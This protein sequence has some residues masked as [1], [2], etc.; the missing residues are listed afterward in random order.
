MKLFRALRNIFSPSARAARRA[1]REEREEASEEA[2]KYWQEKLAPEEDRPD[3]A[4][5]GYTTG[6]S[7]RELLRK[8]ALM[9]VLKDPYRLEGGYFFKPGNQFD[10]LPGELRNKIWNMVLPPGRTII[11]E[12]YEPIRHNLR[13]NRIT[14]RLGVFAYPEDRKQHAVVQVSRE[15]RDIY[16]RHYGPF[17]SS[18]LK[19]PIFID[20]AVDTLCFAEINAMKA[21]EMQVSKYLLK[22]QSLGP[23]KKVAVRGVLIDVAVEWMLKRFQGLEELTFDST[24]ANWQYRHFL[25]TEWAAFGGARPGIFLV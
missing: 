10:D 18:H 13:Y 16:R 22:K 7:P 2:R 15:S 1:E 19:Y 6:N 24:T 17:F 12:Y 21:L 14:H 23:L 9:G 11:L 4:M 25:N 8:G 20:F 5:G 3:K